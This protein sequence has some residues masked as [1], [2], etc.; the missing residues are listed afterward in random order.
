MLLIGSSR[1]GAAVWSRTGRHGWRQTQVTLEAHS[2]DK[3]SYD[4]CDVKMIK[5]VMKIMMMTEIIIMMTII[6]IK[7]MTIMFIKMIMV[8]HH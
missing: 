8:Y 3:V 2:V 5:L 6:L 7:M 4:D 1:Y